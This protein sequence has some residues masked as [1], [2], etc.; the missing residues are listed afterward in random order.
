MR[1]NGFFE[2]SLRRHRKKLASLLLGAWL[3]ALFAGIANACLPEPGNAGQTA[4]MAMGPGHDG[5]DSQSP[6]CRQLCNLDTPLLSKLR[7]VQDQPA[8]Q[9]L[10]VASVSTALL[11]PVPVSVVRMV[12]LAHP[13]PDVPVLLRSLRLAL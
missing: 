13:P 6:D 9:P 4:G 3:F 1:G 11:S 5:D 2:M 7:L 12:Y 8:G 10:L